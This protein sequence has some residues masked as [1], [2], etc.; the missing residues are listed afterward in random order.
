[1][2]RGVG[3]LEG[4]KILF[5]ILN[6]IDKEK[7]FPGRTEACIMQEVTP[8]TFPEEWAGGFISGFKIFAKNDN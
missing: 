3:V 4:V 1:M 5:E 2:G 7:R 6:E 8:T